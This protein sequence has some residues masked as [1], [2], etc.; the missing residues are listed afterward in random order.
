MKKKSHAR[1]SERGSALVEFVFCCAVFWVPLF[2]GT[3][4]VGFNLVQALQVTQVCRDAAHMYAFGVDFSQ[5]IYKNLLVSLGPDL[6]M[7]TNGGNG[8]VIFSTVTY[9]AQA[10]CNAAGYPSCS[11]LN[12]NVFTRRI[13][14]GNTAIRASAFGTPSPASNQVDSSGNLT[15]DFYMNN[16]SAQANGFSSVISLSSGQVAYMA[17]MVV[18]SPQY[19]WWASLGT[20]TEAARFIF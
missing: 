1:S 8:V 14:V 20:P 12:K 6:K 4:V 11:N 10:D 15:V 5:D 17:E 13:V 18:N 9:I 2:F 19:N 7:T 16:A 3:L